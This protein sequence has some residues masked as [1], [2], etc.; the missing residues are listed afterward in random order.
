MAEWVNGLAFRNIAFSASGKPIIKIAEIKNGIS[1]QTKFTNQEFDESFSVNYGD[2]LFSWSGQPETSIDAFWWR[3][4]DGWLNQHIFRVTPKKGIERS[5]FYYLLRYLKPNFI[6]IARNKQTTGLGHVTR[7]DLEAII[8]GVPP[9]SEQK[10]IAHILGSLD[11]KIELNRQ[12]NETLEAMARTLFQSWFVE[13]DPVQAKVEGEETGLPLRI[14]QLFPEELNY[15][16]EGRI[17]LD[18]KLGTLHEFAHL[19][20]ESWTARR[21]PDEVSYVDLSNAKRGHISNVST[22][23]WENAPSRA[24]RVL[25][26][27]D[28]ILG[29]VRPGNQSFALIDEDGLTGSTGFAVLRPRIEI[30]R[31]YVW[32]AA[33]SPENIERLA[34]LADGGAYPAVRPDMVL[35]TKAALATPEIHEIFSRTMAPMLSRVAANRREIACLSELRDTL[36][37]RLISGKLC[38][39][40]WK[41]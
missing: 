11:D 19:N 21:P 33:T 22:F 17:P 8:A 23:P 14:A 16:D 24:R 30:Y 3:G 35:H 9:L 6:G 39:E 41:Q 26:T 12:M 28:T 15:T 13:F 1:G 27:G 20:P 5:F 2:L 40:R 7:R 4:S 36:L 31:E 25:R 32:C 34:H 37:P 38:P 29:T 18:W 10:A